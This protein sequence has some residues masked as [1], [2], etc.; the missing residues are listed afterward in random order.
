MSCSNYR[1]TAVLQLFSKLLEK[2]MHKK[3]MCYL[4]KLNLLYEHQFGFQEGKS[5]EQAITDL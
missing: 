3:L 1:P 2:L 4:K 5:T